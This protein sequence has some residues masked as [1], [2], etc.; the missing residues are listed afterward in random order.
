MTGTPAPK[1]PSLSHYIEPLLKVLGQRVGFKAGVFIPNK[2]IIPDIIREA[3]FDPDNLEQYGDPGMGWSYEGQKPAGFRRQVSLAHRK[4]YS[5]TGTVKLPKGQPQ[6]TMTGKPRGQMALTDEGVAKAK[7]LCGVKDDGTS[8]GGNATAQFLDKRLAETGGIGGKLYALMCAAVISK[9]PLSATIGIVED[10]VQNCLLNLIRRN[11]LKGRLAN[12]VRIT[13]SHLATYA[14]RTGFTDIRK[15]GTEPVCR[16]MYGART[17]RERAKQVKLGP[18]NDERLSWSKAEDGSFTISDVADA[19][20]QDG[21]TVEAHLAFD[22]MW[23]NIR[24]VVREKKPKVWERYVKILFHVANGWSIKEIAT[25]EGVSRHRA[26]SLVNT[27]RRCVREGRAEDLLS[28][29]L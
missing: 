7:E 28:A 6:L 5:K 4:L 25:A 15:D 13:D 19:E 8:S 16:E 27:A 12:G 22:D 9:L 1:P 17:E 29:V 14:V 11:A 24:A 18:L 3:G 10:H 20:S 21:A 26:A 2:D 23:E